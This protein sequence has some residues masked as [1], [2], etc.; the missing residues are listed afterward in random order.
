[1]LSLRRALLTATRHASPTS[2][3]RVNIRLAYSASPSASQRAGLDNLNV[4][5]RD[6][7]KILKVIE[8]RVGQRARLVQQVD[9]TAADKESIKLAKT[10]K[11]LEPLQ[12][13]WDEWMRAKEA[14]M[15]SLPLL[16]DPDPTMRAMAED[17]YSTQLS[18]LRTLM[19]Q[20]FPPLLVPPSRTER[21]GALLEL[22]AGVGGAEAELFRAELAK[23]YIRAAQ[24]KGWRVEGDERSDAIEI[25][26]DGAYDIFRWESGVH[27]VQRV[28]QTESSGRIH[29]S[30]ISVI[31]LPLT[32]ERD[33][34]DLGNI[35][36]EKDVKVEVMRSS[37][38][39]GQHVNKTESAV[40]LTHIPTGITVAMQD[41]R[42]QPQNRA[43]AWRVLRAR[44]LDRALAEDIIRRREA[45]RSVV[46]TSD[47][48]DK[49]RTY[50]FPQDRVTDHRISFQM[51]GLETIMSGE[52]LDVLTTELQK[53]QDMELLEELAEEDV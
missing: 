40:R 30:T 1:M 8:K 34:L 50:N 13:A 49:I 51:N 45:R 44:L 7:A 15:Q 4:I 17:E 26:D 47:R 20:T 18:T 25:R 52:R 29:T 43:K 5:E 31:C 16:E 3:R 2:T 53:A 14:F 46:R 32:E 11:E 22:K 37:G 28:P 36:N 39:G 19:S 38:A 24:I 27:R 10:L 35:L 6:G 21:C 33:S 23:A 41:E 12:E 48:S 9:H 42:S